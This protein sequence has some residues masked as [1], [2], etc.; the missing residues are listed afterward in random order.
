MKQFIDLINGFCPQNE[1]PVFSKDGRKFF[2]VRAIPQG[3]QG[4]FYHITVSSSQVSP[5]QVSPPSQVSPLP[6]EP[7]QFLLSEWDWPPGA[8]AECTCHLQG[9]QRGA[10]PQNWKVAPPWGQRGP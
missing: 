3:G 5:P 7:P 4:K 2:F 10:G 1:E 6:G 9:V 8:R